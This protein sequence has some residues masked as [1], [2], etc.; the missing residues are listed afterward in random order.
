MVVVTMAVCCVGY[1]A[2]IWTVGAVLVPGKAEGSLVRDARGQ[3]IG[4]G[5]I[6]QK[7]TQPRYFWPR[8]SAVDYNAAGTGGSN[9]SPTNPAL[10]ERATA[11]VAALSP[12]SGALIPADLVTASGSGMDPH[13]TEAGARYQAER[14]AA[15]RGA[16]VA[17]VE[18]LI[19]RLA[20]S[21]EGLGLGDRIVNVLELNLALD[22]EV[23]VAG[24]A[25]APAENAPAN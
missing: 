6:A 21:P 16:N 5:P 12:E 22:R 2:L 11:S 14:V 4:S 19:D 10:T 1:T 8:P 18:A 3:V 24:V 25:S 17:D 20:A 23:K 13:I 7:F 15:A 9:L